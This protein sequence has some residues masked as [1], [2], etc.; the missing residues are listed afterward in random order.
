MSKQ[1]P[2]RSFFDLRTLCVVFWAGSDLC[3]YARVVDSLYGDI[4]VVGDQCQNV[5]SVIHSE[6]NTGTL[7]W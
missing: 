4:L 6:K 3:G 5:G 1:A 7:G 2:L